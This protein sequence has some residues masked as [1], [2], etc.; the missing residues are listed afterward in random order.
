MVSRFLLLTTTMSSIAYFGG[1]S[2]RVV[3]RSP[4][5]IEA[6]LQQTPCQAA[7]E[8]QVNLGK[9]IDTLGRDYPHMLQ[10]PPDYSIYES[11]VRCCSGDTCL[12]GMTQYMRGEIPNFPNLP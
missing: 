2:P 12:E 1:L 10:A 9:A 8:Y 4:L 3:N 5:R 6:N 7:N 11:S